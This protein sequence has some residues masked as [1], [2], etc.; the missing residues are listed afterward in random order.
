MSQMMPSGGYSQIVS[1]INF[2]EIRQQVSDSSSARFYPHLLERLLSFDTT[3]TKKDYQALYYGSVFQP[4]Y[5]PY[6]ENPEKA[7]FLVDYRDIDQLEQDK[8]KFDLVVRALKILQQNPIDLEILIGIS[9]IYY[10]LGNTSMT[11][12]YAGIYYHFL[13][14]IYESGDGLSD[15]TAF[16]VTSV[17]DEYRI[18]ADLGLHVMGQELIGDCDLLSFSR[19]GQKGRKIKQLYFNVRMPLASLSPSYDKSNL[20]DPDPLPDE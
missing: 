14:V 18:V 5:Q 7:G 11:R 3:L 6:W 15:E 13:D 20:P 8:D 12:K 9:I 2:G 1:S 10:H 4:D 17:H 19:S 16:V